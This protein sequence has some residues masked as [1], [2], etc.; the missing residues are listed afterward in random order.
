L[1]A[2]EDLVHFW[3]EPHFREKVATAFA[4]EAAWLRTALAAA[5]VE[6]V[7]S[8]AIP[9]SLTKGDL[10]I[11]V[12][13]RPVEFAAA[14]R[15]LLVRY[16]RNTGS[17]PQEGFAA[18]EKPGSTPPIGVQLTAIGGEVDVFWRFR[19]VLLLRPDLVREYDALKRW[20]EGKPMADYRAA[21]DAFFD[22]LRGTAE[23]DRVRAGPPDG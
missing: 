13:V 9:G 18:F 19:D 2:I 5:Q 10:D 20:F 16:R 22:R 12:R 11:Q 8:T 7:G 3:P 17:T 6:H 14:E 4:S 23:F 1:G 21:K 15:L